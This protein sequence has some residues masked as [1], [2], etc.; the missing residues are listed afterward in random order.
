MLAVCVATLPTTNVGRGIRLLYDN[1]T[2]LIY[3]QI[4]ILLFYDM[5]NKIKTSLFTIIDFR[6]RTM[7]N[8]LLR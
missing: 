7:E 5:G 2:Y 4:F 6:L 1:K 3:I 8:L